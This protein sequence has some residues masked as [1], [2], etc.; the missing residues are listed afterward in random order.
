MNILFILPGIPRSITGGS[1]VVYEYSNWL[2][3]KGYDVEI[4]YYHKRK[5]SFF[6]KDF[7]WRMSL[8]LKANFLEPRWFRLD[9]NIKRKVIYKT[10]DIG[11][12]SDIIVV[13]AIE[14]AEFVRDLE[15]ENYFYFIQDFENWNRSNE[16]VYATYNM[17]MTNIVVAKWLKDI[18]DKHSSSPSYLVSNCINTDVFYDKGENRRKHSLVFHYRT[19][20]YKG[21]QYALEAIGKLKEKYEDIIVD[22]ISSEEKPDNLPDYCNFH[23]N[24]SPIEVAEINNK[25]EVFM[26]TT[27][28]EGFGLPGLEAMA[29][30]CAV[31]S[32]AY[33]GVL[34]Y[35]VDGENALL[36]QVRDVDAMVNNIVKIFEDD[37]LRE[38][39]AINGVITG[40]NRSLSKSAKMFEKILLGKRE[41]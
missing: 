34:E 17:G 3:K 30:G 8:S 41:L 23:H 15:K 11:V 37:K 22:V 7:L 39:I 29:C 16:E 38:K 14:T 5:Y 40:K 13:T 4:N 12:K 28:D 26:C 20:D 1:K 2:S 9:G 21:P 33:R 6:L 31:V 19:A 10:S 25:T 36:S 27:I 18:V 32:S 24:I 35:A